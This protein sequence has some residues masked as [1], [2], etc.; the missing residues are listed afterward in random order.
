MEG[1]EMAVKTT[2]GLDTAVEQVCFEGG[3]EGGKESVA[4]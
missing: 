4:A 1:T 2:A 3:S